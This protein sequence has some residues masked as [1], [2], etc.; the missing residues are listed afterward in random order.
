M[1]IT[2]LRGKDRGKLREKMDQNSD[3]IIDYVY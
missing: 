1:S 2:E 3:K